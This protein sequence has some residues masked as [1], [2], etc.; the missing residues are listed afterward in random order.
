MN[1]VHEK[2]T[3]LLVTLPN[4]HQFKK[5]HSRN[6]TFFLQRILD[7]SLARLCQKSD[8]RRITNQ[9]PLSPSLSPVVSISLGILHER[10]RTQMLAKSSS[11]LLQRTGGD[12]RGGRAQSGWGT[13]MMTCLRWILGYVRL[14]IWRK[15]GL[16]GDW[17]LCTALRTRSSAC[18]CW[19]G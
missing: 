16:S 6:K 11:N 14:E 3:F 9:P 5:N 8:I 15:I 7:I 2:I 10:T 12:H 1:K 18:Y 19:T 4:I 17:C 13:F